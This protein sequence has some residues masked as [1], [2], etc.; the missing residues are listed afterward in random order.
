M[1]NIKLTTVTLSPVIDIHY[2]FEEFRTESENNAASVIKNAAGKGINISRALSSFGV[3]CR[4]MAL[5][6]RENADSYLKMLEKDGVSCEYVLADG[7]VRE[8]VSLNAC[9]MNETRILTDTFNPGKDCFANLMYDVNLYSADNSY[10]AISGRIPKSIHKSDFIAECKKLNG[11]LVLDTASLSA[12]ELADV[13]P[14]LIKPNQN[15]ANDLL[16]ISCDAACGLPAAR[17]LLQKKCASNVIISLGKD[18]FV[19][20]GEY[21]EAVVKVPETEVKATVGAGDST[22]AGILFGIYNNFNFF[23]CLK[24][25]AA[26]GSAACLEYGTVPPSRDN[27]IKILSQIVL[28]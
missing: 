4:T 26:F 28:K 27:V 21:G 20:A 16:G 22:I 18:G 3:P 15:E 17:L 10:I 1:T 11:R 23:D 12:E 14:W 24:T 13:S 25:G 6:G 5:L 8:S 2:Q 7:S 19:Y 9:G